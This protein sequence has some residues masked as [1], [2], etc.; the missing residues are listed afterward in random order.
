MSD[1]DKL[2][3]PTGSLTKKS[4]WLKRVRAS[5]SGVSSS[6]ELVSTAYDELP[7]AEQSPVLAIKTHREREFNS[8]SSRSSST[9]SHVGQQQRDNIR[10][11]RP[12]TTIYAAHNSAMFPPESHASQMRT[13]SLQGPRPLPGQPQMQ[14]HPSSTASAFDGP[15][16]T[17]SN[18]NSFASALTQSRTNVTGHRPR[19]SDAVSMRSYASEQDRMSFMS[20]DSKAPF[21]TQNLYKFGP[22][23][24]FPQPQSTAEIER[25][26]AEMMSARDLFRQM[27]DDSRRQLM[28][29]PIT[30]KWQMIYAD[31]MTVW[32]DQVSRK[33]SEAQG[34]GSKGSPD[35]YVKRIV[36]QTLKPSQYTA[37]NVCLRTLQVS[38]VREFI[39]NQGHIALATALGQVNQRSSKRDDDITKEHEILKC[40]KVVLNNQVSMIVRMP[41]Q[42]RLIS[43]VRSRRNY[44]SSTMH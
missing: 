1:R 28:S 8:V 12:P 18:A 27:P 41:I 6:D 9:S 22:N 2:K 43:I 4:G 37:L 19:R 33:S 21:T 14:N 3:T 10:E 16:R 40:L 35:W 36:D 13:N 17:K 24:E 38:W 29:K 26:F 31:A 23:G 20:T 25:L 32:R 7:R 15:S 44:E 42:H 5:S 34:N 30:V 39:E 11:E